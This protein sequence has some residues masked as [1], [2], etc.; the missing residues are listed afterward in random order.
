MKKRENELHEPKI[1]VEFNPEIEGTFFDDLVRIT[2]HCSFCHKKVYGCIIPY[3]K[4]GKSFVNKELPNY[5]LH[6]GARLKE[7]GK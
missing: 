6:C 7:V 2:A 5:C 4:Y 1:E 3:E